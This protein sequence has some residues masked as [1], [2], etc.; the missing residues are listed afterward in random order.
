ESVIE[1][2]EERLSSFWQ[3]LNRIA[4]TLS[5]PVECLS[6]QSFEP[7]DQM[8]FQME[9][10]IIVRTAERSSGVFLGRC[11]RYI[12]RDHPYLFNIL[13]HA[14]MADRIYRVQDLFCLQA[15][16]AKKLITKN[17]RDRH[18]YMQ[19]F[20]SKDWLDARWYDLCVN[21]SSLGMEQCVTAA[22]FGLQSK[23][24]DC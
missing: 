1:G 18:A 11:G 20:A 16:D 12:L 3:S 17:D 21:T 5:D 23:I 7:D 9:S 2:R 4:V 14:N 8:L 6:M 10:E 13:V 15:E 19:T 24:A 22:M